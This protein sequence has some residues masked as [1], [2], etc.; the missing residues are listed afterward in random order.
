MGL[1]YY[2]LNKFEKDGLIVLIEEIGLGFKVR[3]IYKIIDNGRDEL[4]GFVKKEIVNELLLNGFDKFIIYLLL[5][6]FDK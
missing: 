3:K 6:I 4:K 5:N 2:V 1:I